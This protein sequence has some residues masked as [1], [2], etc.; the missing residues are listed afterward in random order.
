M[1][2]DCKGRFTSGHKAI[3]DRDKNTGRFI[4]KENVSLEDKVDCILMQH[5]M[6]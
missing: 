3:P 6:L 1:V 5:D 2:R 4:T